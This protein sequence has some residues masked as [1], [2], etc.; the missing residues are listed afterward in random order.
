MPPSG[1]IND[2][3]TNASASCESGLRARSLCP[4]RMVSMVCVAGKTGAR[5]AHLDGTASP[6][7]SR[8][9]S[10]DL[11]PKN[12]AITRQ[13][14]TKHCRRLNPDREAE[15]FRD[16]D[17]PTTPFAANRHRS[18]TVTASGRQPQSFTSAAIVAP[19]TR[20]LPLKP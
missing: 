3:L 14:A 9:G 1:R 17:R 5:H 8:V 2:R 18:R 6:Q 11:P 7:A 19:D 12:A 15:S 20:K 13:A 10:S 16:A 4:T